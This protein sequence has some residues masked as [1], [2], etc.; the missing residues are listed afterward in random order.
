MNIANKK[1]DNTDPCLTP[2]VIWNIWDQLE[3]HLTQAIIFHFLTA[4]NMQQGYSKYE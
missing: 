2:E 1:G 3:P 4:K